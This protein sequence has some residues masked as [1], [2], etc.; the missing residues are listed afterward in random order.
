ME[1]KKQ[2]RHQILRDAGRCVGCTARMASV[3]PFHAYCAPCRAARR[4]ERTPDA[5][6]AA[7][8]DLLA[9]R[10]DAAAQVPPALPPSAVLACCGQWHT[11]DSV[12]FTTPCCGRTLRAQPSTTGGTLP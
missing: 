8:G 5:H 9:A 12:P 7:L 3:P 10:R 4:H 1:R 6:V 11:I 2:L